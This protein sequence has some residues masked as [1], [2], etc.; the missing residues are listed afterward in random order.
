VTAPYGAGPLGDMPEPPGKHGRHRSTRRTIVLCII[1]GVVIVLALGIISSALDGSG[2][3]RTPAASAGAS[4]PAS[5]PSPTPS[6]TPSLSAGETKFVNAIRASVLAAGSTI[7]ES[8]ADIAKIGTDVCSGREAGGSQ[9]SMISG[10]QTGD[11]RKNVNMSARHL[12]LLAER[13]ICPS[14]IPVVQT[15]TYIVTGGA[16]ASV[17]YGPEGS[18]LNGSDPMNVTQDIP[19]SVPDYYAIDA[20]LQGG[21]QVSC[22]IEIDGK[23]ISTATASGGYNIASCE[24]DQNP[25]TGQWENTNAG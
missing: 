22:T 18:N 13:D 23:A 12:V 16:G 6:P 3:T 21:G 10:A 19:S 17:Q 7:G 11:P 2:K 9:A 24:A 5:T 8:N 15:V 14:E 25:L 4:A 20:Q 1:A